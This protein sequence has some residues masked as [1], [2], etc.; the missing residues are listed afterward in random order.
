MNYYQKIAGYYDALMES[1]YYDH[2]KL[3]QTVH[4][5]IG[6]G[7]KVLEIGVGTGKM[8]EELAAIDPSSDFC[9]VDFSGAM[10]EIAN[11]RLSNRFPM[12]ECDIS[13]MELDQTF[14]VVLSC[15][16][17]WIVQKSDEGLCLGTHLFSPDKDRLG[18][19]KV[20][21]HLE[22][23]GRLVLSVHPPHTDRQLE[24]DNGMVYSQKVGD[25]QGGTDHFYLEKTY[26]FLQGDE[27]LAEETM[28]LGFYKENIF[29]PM[30]TGAGFKPL[31]LTETEEFFVF[32]KVA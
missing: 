1:G 16:G 30:F 15:G 32:E 20:S 31:G 17:A 4:S 22:T 3:A 9:G 12:V 8:V 23:G 25:Y 28:T 24:M 5:V 13:T 10:I 26:S 2:A 27:T 29:Q 21:K 11:R 6:S 14:D 19:E 7:K 18:F